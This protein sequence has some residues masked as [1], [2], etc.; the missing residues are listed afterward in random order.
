MAATIKM[1]AARA[2]VSVATIS[3]YINGG[4]VI[5]ENRVKVQDAID[6]LNYKINEVARSLKMNK[7][8]TIGILASSINS[9]FISSVIS[10]MQYRLLELGYSS[11]IADFQENREVEDK[12]IE[13]LLK[14]Q[15]DGIVMF[16]LENEKSI[17]N[18][19]KQQNIPVVMVDN[20]IEDVE[21][22][23]VLSDSMKGIYGEVEHLIKKGHE[24]IG[25]ITGPE[26]MYTARERMRGYTEA[27]E[28]YKRDVRTEY[29]K[30]S[31]YNLGG[32]YEAMVELIRLEDRPT[33]VV[34][35]NYYT[36]LGALKALKD[37]GVRISEDMTLVV[38]DEL[39]FLCI[40]DADI[41]TIC[42]PVKAMGI[43]AAERIIQRISGDMEEFPTVDRLE[44]RVI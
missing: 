28:L 30:Y 40:L 9:D 27:Y 35:G 2:G 17:I 31:D 44:T 21:C 10:A 32:G 36:A 37:E 43:K 15:V 25:I 13:T 42:Q 1:V 26:S 29:I 20:Y 41:R 34:A 18:F 22:D 24:K 4:N 8:N 16:P 11:V 7:T 14:R 38:F 3:K 5:P 23:A 12:Q 39:D 19:I 6:E 33:A